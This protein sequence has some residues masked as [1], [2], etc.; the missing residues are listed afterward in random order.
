MV[1]SFASPAGRLAAHFGVAPDGD[2]VMRPAGGPLLRSPFRRV[3]AAPARGKV[4]ARGAI[5]PDDLADPFLE[6]AVRADMD[7]IFRKAARPRGYADLVDVVTA[8]YAEAVAIAVGVD[9]LVGL[10][11]TPRAGAARTA[12]AVR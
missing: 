4:A 10:G 9:V 12:R 8:G 2:I 7:A 5:R 6:R 1:P 3:A 11:L